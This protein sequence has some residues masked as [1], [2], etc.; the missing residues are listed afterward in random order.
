MH[1]LRRFTG[2]STKNLQKACAQRKT[3]NPDLQPKSI[4]W[5]LQETTS[6][7]KIFKSRLSSTLWSLNKL[8]QITE[9]STNDRQPVLCVTYLIDVIFTKFA[10]AVFWIPKFN[11]C[12]KFVNRTTFFVTSWNAA[13]NSWC[14]KRS[15]FNAISNSVGISRLKLGFLS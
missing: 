9:A 7:Q 2:N 13:P 14:N 4:D 8:S 15:S 12:F 3:T 11:F 10:W 6:H 5:F 1:I